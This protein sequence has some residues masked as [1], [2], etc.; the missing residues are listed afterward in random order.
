VTT[1]LCEQWP[2]SPMAYRA[3]GM[4]RALEN[5]VFY[6]S[7]NLWG[8]SDPDGQLR[9]IG[10]WAIIAPWGEVLAEVEAGKGAAVAAVDFEAPEGWS[11]AA[12]PCREDRSRL[13]F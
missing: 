4:T 7:A 9:A 2:Y 1:D 11:Q 5:G 8:A 12:A 3:M 13:G 10:Q 6:M